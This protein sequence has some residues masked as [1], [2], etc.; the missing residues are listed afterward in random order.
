[1]ADTFWDA[2]VQAVALHGDLEFSEAHEAYHQSQT[3]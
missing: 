1:M 3:H 2:Q